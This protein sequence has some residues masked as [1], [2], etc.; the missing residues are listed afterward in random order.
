MQ[1]LVAWL[2]PIV[3]WT[4][5]KTLA[6][7]AVRHNST[8]LLDIRHQHITILFIWNLSF[9]NNCLVNNMKQQGLASGN[10]MM[11]NQQNMHHPVHQSAMQNGP[12][13]MARINAM[14]QSNYPVSKQII[15]VDGTCFNAYLLILHCLC[16]K[17]IRVWHFRHWFYVC[18]ISI[19][20]HA[21][22]NAKPTYVE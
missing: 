5:C 1:E 17:Q 13:G 16:R 22:R 4:I 2:W 6:W 7:L 8:I 3:I 21:K 19:G 20:R 15:S 12:M 18:L 14:Q 10:M 11:N 9:S